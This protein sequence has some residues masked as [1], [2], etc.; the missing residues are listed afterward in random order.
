MPSDI[1][2]GYTTADL[3][4]RWRVSP[5]KVRGWIERGEL[6]ALNVAT[7]ACARPRYVVTADAVAAFERRRSAAPTPKA[8]RRRR[9]KSEIHDYYPD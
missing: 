7:H 5:D 1:H 9:A 6:A 3:S 8:P 4:A 2:P